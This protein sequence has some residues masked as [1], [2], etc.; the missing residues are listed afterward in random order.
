MIG[1]AYILV[2]LNTKYSHCK[3]YYYNVM[4]QLHYIV[5]Q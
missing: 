3:S 1:V 5:I 4:L 2:T